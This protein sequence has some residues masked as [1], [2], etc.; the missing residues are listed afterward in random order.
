MKPL[1]VVPT[2]L[3]DPEE[4][5][6]TLTM[7]RSLRA[8][9]PKVGVLVV[10]DGS[11]VAGLVDEL[12]AQTSG[13]KLEIHR[14]E[15]NSGFSQ[16]VNVGLERARD[17]GRDA[18]LANADLEFLD[19]GWVARM[20]K[21]TNSK[22]EPASVVGA[23][24]VY[25]NGLIQHAGVYY[26]SP[27]DEPV[28]T[29]DGYVP[30]SQLAGARGLV[31]YNPGANRILRHDRPGR[32]RSGGYEFAVG[33]RPYQGSMLTISAGSSETRV[34]PNHAI[35]V[36]WSARG[37]NATA[38]Y[39]MRRG[40]DWK[41]G[42]AGVQYPSTRPSSMARGLYT[43]LA[44]ERADDLWILG[45]YDDK[46]DAHWHEKQIAWTFGVPTLQFVYRPQDPIKQARQDALWA[47]LD[48]ASAA[49]ALMRS[50]GL[51]AGAPF[52]RYGVGRGSQ[53]PRLLVRACNLQPGFMRVPTD[54]GHRDPEFRE[55]ALRTG[56]Y[57]GDV[58]SLD[59][60]P[61]HH[62]VSGGVVVHNSLLHRDFDHI[63]RY[64]PADLPEALYA[65]TCPVT[66]ALQFIRNECLREV[67][68]YDPEFRM[69]WEDVDYCLRVF[70]SGRSCVYQPAVRAIHH[71]SLFRGKPS[72]KVQEWE[73]RSKIL[74]LRKWA[75]TSL[76]RWVS[77][78]GLEALQEAA[79]IREG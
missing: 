9:E 35:T 61:Y 20:V 28:L 58:Y 33:H 57:T 46:E 52:M 56:D 63:F 8:T 65:R 6:V 48:S 44:L 43:R 2:Y 78:P 60:P 55:F 30:I 74:L 18:I 10:D 66:G 16:T 39:L 62:Y 47:E 53:G 73:A 70:A 12:E 50:F 69:A 21:Q 24:L 34:T 41:V 19:E 45:L 23:R 4:L 29:T 26:C 37:L 79:R 14:K 49:A 64:A 25:P 13:L 17:E 42:V 72:P 15:E 5:D 51:D 22:G 31:G 36:A 38:V 75:H 59:V 68:V 76:T 11:P 67:G 77:D 40:S 1:V 3:S 27:P 54:V 71:E 32:G 7:L